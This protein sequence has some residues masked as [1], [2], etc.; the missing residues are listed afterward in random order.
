[1]RRPAVRARLQS[2]LAALPQQLVSYEELL[3]F[4]I[5]FGADL[6][7][8]LRIGDDP[9][10][11]SYR[12]VRTATRLALELLPQLAPS[13]PRLRYTAA[14]L[15]KCVVP[16]LHAPA[17]TPRARHL[18]MH[19]AALGVAKQQGSDFYTAVCGYAMAAST[20]DWVA[21]SAVQQGLPAPSAVLDW[22]QQANAAH[23][24]CK[25]LLPKQWAGQLVGMKALAA[26]AKAILQ[27]LQQQ[28]DS[29]RPLTTATLQEL[30]TALENCSKISSMKGL[31]CH[32]CGK[33]AP[34][35]RKCGACK[36]AQYCR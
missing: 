11:L 6:A 30:N 3:A 34:Q 9:A 10:V 14:S 13:N 31:T 4:F 7:L 25:A 8:D 23:R 5:V 32:G 24:R 20:D 21:E 27:S 35:L 33:P 36:E 16:R 22:L 15:A 19:H 17:E 28:G 29:W 12:D 18:A 1:M 26:S 2:E